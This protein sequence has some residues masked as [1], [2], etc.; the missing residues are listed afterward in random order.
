MRWLL[1]VLVVFLLFLQYRLWVGEGSLAQKQVLQH[2]VEMQQQ[3]NQVQLER[4][5]IL[6]SD[7]SNLKEGLESVEERARTDLGMIKEGETFYMVV[8]KEPDE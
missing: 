3:E 5:K 1:A 2:K 6:A 7:V 8:D 4:N